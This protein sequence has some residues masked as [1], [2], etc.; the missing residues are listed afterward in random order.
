MA[1]LPEAFPAGAAADRAGAVTPEEAF[2]HFGYDPDHPHGRD[3]PV[4]ARLLR[5]LERAPL[6]DETAIRGCVH[7]EAGKLTGR[8]RELLT[9]LSHGL[10]LG[11]AADAMG[12]TVGTAR[13][14]RQTA[15]FK[16]RAKTTTHA[17][18]LALRQGLIS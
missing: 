13:E 8:E 4:P 7:G 9:Y 6:I 1:R 14:F 16:L 10:T 17:V 3:D 11:M 12:V 15:R 2:R 5:S 18:A